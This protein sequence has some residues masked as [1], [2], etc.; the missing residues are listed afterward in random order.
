MP[1]LKEVIDYAESVGGV[2]DPVRF[3]AVNEQRGWLAA[4]N[5][6]RNWK[7]LY[8]SWCSYEQRDGSLQTSAKTH[9][10]IEVIPAHVK[11]I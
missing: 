1:S 2:A 4:G 11:I 7:M 5:P 6:I 9:N 3:H 8:L 10:P